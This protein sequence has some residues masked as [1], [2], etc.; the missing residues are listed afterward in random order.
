[1]AASQFEQIASTQVPIN[2]LTGHVRKSRLHSDFVNRGVFSVTVRW[3]M[4]A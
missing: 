2:A 4:A 3:V 1:M